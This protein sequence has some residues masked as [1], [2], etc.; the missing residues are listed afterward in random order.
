MRLQFA[1][2]SPSRR[3]EPQVR[4]NDRARHLVEAAARAS[5]SGSLFTPPGSIADLEPLSLAVASAGA[6]RSAPLKASPGLSVTRISTTRR[7]V[8]RN[9]RSHMAHVILQK[10]ECAPNLDANALSL[11]LLRWKKSLL[12]RLGSD[13]L[14]VFL[15]LPQKTPMCRPS[16]WSLPGASANC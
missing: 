3:K 9:P 5:F 16:Y 2:K 1:F 11:R 15:D 4:K 14:V 6:A 13:S 8:A 12:H 10:P 7:L